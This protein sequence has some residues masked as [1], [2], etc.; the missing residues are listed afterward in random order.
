MD[1]LCPNCPYNGINCDGQSSH[2]TSWCPDE[3]QK[4]MN[5]I[6][7][8]GRIGLYNTGEPNGICWEIQA[9]EYTLEDFDTK[10]LAMR[11]TVKNITDQ[12][13]PI[14]TVK[15][16]TGCGGNCVRNDGTCQGTG[17]D[18]VNRCVGGNTDVVCNYG[19]DDNDDNDD[20]DN[21]NDNNN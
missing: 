11:T 1:N 14:V 15:F 4:P 2:N 20:N 17:F 7:N 21:D 3:E 6:D 16:A 8:G 18:C 9:T 12:D 13:N 19:E 5:P 10:D